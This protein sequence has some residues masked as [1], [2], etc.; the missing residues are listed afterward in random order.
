MVASVV[1]TLWRLLYEV[2]TTTLEIE[3]ILGFMMKYSIPVV[4][5]CSF[6]TFEYGGGM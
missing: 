4:D 1:R 2:Y 6:E 5:I 3:P